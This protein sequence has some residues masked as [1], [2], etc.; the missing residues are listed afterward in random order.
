MGS[1]AFSK[2]CYLW[3]GTTLLLSLLISPRDIYLHFVLKLIHEEEQ[4]EKGK[5]IFIYYLIPNIYICVEVTQNHSIT[6]LT[7]CLCYY[8]RKLRYFKRTN[9]FFFQNSPLSWKKN[10]SQTIIKQIKAQRVQLDS[11]LANN[12]KSQCFQWL[13][14]A[15][16][17][18][19]FCFDW[20]KYCLQHQLT[21]CKFPRTCS[22]SMNRFYALFTY[23]KDC[24]L[25]KLTKSNTDCVFQQKLAN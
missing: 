20:L 9:D 13:V 3:G 24:R 1:N 15:I 10:T 6:T 14:V 19:Q 12:R 23:T 25:C 21:S 2:F 16:K 5:R 4:C 18:F 11:F 7:A 8:L 17:P 22:S